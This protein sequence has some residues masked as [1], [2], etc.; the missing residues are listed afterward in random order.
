MN[1][2]LLQ[3]AWQLCQAG[4]M[5]EATRICQDILRSDPRQIGALHMLGVIH[6]RLEQF[7][8]AERVFSSAVMLAPNSPEI[9]LNRGN[10]RFK[11]ER[12]SEALTD[13][14][15]ALA[16]EPSHA[17]LWN[18]R[19]NALAM[20]ARRE[21][22]IASFTRAIQIEPRHVDALIGRADLY[23]GRG[24]DDE[25]LRDIEQALTISPS[26]ELHYR[27]GILL[28]RRKSPEAA[29]R[30]FDKALAAE[31]RD[32]NCHI[33][34]AMALVALKQTDSAL[35][36]LDS[37]LILDPANAQAL[38]NRASVLARLKRYEEALLS[39]DRA[40]KLQPDLP[41]AWHNR[42]AAL[43][44]LKR[45]KEA[46]ASYEKA[47]A[48]APQ[49]AHTWNNAGAAM[50]LLERNEAALGYFERALQ[51]HARDPEIWSNRA[52]AFA[53]LNRFPEAL[54]D[55][56]KAL[57]LEADHVPALRVA[58]H[59]RLRSCDWSR[60]DHDIS[61]IK[62]ALR[63]G[64]RI[65][66]PLHCLALFD[67]GAENL[68]AAQLWTEEECPPQSGSIS[69]VP[70]YSHDRL[71]IAYLSSDLRAHAVG[72]LIAG[73][74]EYHDKSRL[75][76]TAL[77]YGP[78]DHSP[79]RARMQAAFD[80]FI[81]IREMT[82]F[83]VAKL[84][85]EMEID[86]LIDLNG[87]TGNMRTGIAAFHPAPAQ[88]N[89][90]GY[91][92]T[93]GTPTIDYIIADPVL[94]P[95]SQ[96]GF[97]SETV[98][99]LPDCY[100]P[101]DRQRVVAPSIPSRGEA[102]LPQSGFVFCCFNNNYKIGPEIFDIWMRLLGATPGSVLWLLQDNAT[103][104]ANL[105]REAQAR[106][107]AADRLIF[108]SRTTSAAHLAR[109]ALA[110]LFLD[111]LPYNA[112]TTASDAV[113]MGLP[114]ITCPGTSFQSRVAASILTA[115]GMPELI[116]G[117]LADYETL[118]LKLASDRQFM[119]AIRKKLAANRETC[120]L[121]DIQHFT[122]NLETIYARIAGRERL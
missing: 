24:R 86:I 76:T 28:L 30:D 66:D 114:L 103:A 12:F 109:H 45:L 82:D 16:R 70:R 58:I 60:R 29:L 26:A 106:G 111:T 92:G 1:Q 116:V 22:A 74:F 49:N 85:R 107:V 105:R 15:A 122:R 11:L 50:I 89:F 10:A 96:R 19:G 71:R 51:L 13:Y 77:S 67:S 6:A 84:I 121:F 93:M 34:R 31:P 55:C 53:G 68:A 87:Y 35:A 63:D 64:R 27:R 83:E 108:A 72:F 69:N 79:T 47:L 104:A 42:G 81:D 65:V 112:H 59:A 61:Q 102:G 52:K 56:A 39:A 37:A 99:Y 25:A 101:N 98:L 75:E 4:Q 18:N 95:E 33:G 5:A 117:S 62:S 78:D 23:S 32:A 48:L 90:L 40:L 44:G 97:Y 9:L 100:Q 7:A 8:D 54:A 80:R 38:S 120:A 20:L 14:D 118:A 115:A 57:A 119:S 36:A 3:K 21:D 110:D 94:I 41:G 91:P 46:V 17:M 113:W 88:V 2:Q 73:V 43:A